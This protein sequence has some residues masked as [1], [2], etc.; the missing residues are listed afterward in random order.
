MAGPK[1]DPRREAVKV[2]LLAGLVTLFFCIQFKDRWPKE[3]KFLPESYQEPVQTRIDVPPPFDAEQESYTYT[4]YPLYS[5]ELWGM[6]VSLHDAASFLDVA[7]EAWKDYLNVKDL[8]IIW[9]RNLETDAFRHMKFRNRDFTCFYSWST[10]EAGE[11]FSGS[12][13]S[14]NHLITPDPRLRRVIRSVKRGDQV[15]IR[16]WLANYGHKGSNYGRA[17]STTRTDKGGHACETVYVTEFEILKHANP[18]WRAAF[19]A[20][21]A[22]IAGSLLLLFLI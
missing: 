11:L 6:V 22:V 13:I 21:L 2:V 18:G 3:Y 10:P 8:C 7:H 12:H 16:G 1:P 20:S 17:T 19:P 4:V 15:R 9:G 14:N 5:Y